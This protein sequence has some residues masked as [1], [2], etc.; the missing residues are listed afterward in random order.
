M[1]AWIPWLHDEAIRP[2]NTSSHSCAPGLSNPS[3]YKHYY[4]VTS[5]CLEQGC[6]PMRILLISNERDQGMYEHRK[7]ISDISIHKVCFIFKH[8]GKP[9]TCQKL[10]YDLL[11]QREFECQVSKQS[12]N[13]S[14]SQPAAGARW[15]WTPLPPAAWAVGLCRVQVCPWERHCPHRGEVLRHS[16]NFGSPVAVPFVFWEDKAWFPSLLVYGGNANPPLVQTRILLFMVS[17]ERGAAAV[18]GRGGRDDLL[19]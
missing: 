12:G 2:A 15:P 13:D 18:W 11:M 9:A 4:S 14:V 5:D 3:I 1:V 16:F 10:N 7:V 17:R 8:R 6:L 19:P